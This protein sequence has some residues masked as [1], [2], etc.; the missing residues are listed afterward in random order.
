MLRWFE[1]LVFFDWA[2]WVKP[3]D[4]CAVEKKGSARRWVTLGWAHSLSKQMPHYI[5]KYMVTHGVMQALLFQALTVKSRIPIWVTAFTV[6][7]SKEQYSLGGFWAFLASSDICIHTHAHTHSVDGGAK[8]KCYP[9][10][11]TIVHAHVLACLRVNY[12]HVFECLCVWVCTQSKGGGGG[13][14]R[15]GGGRREV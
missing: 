2:W 11:C 13:G 15:K 7:W 12:D 14:G 10:V 9:S 8:L 6:Q 4:Y 5:R 1:F 3:S